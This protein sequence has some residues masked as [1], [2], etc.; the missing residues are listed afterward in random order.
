[1]SKRPKRKK[2]WK[3]DYGKNEVKPSYED[4]YPRARAPVNQVAEAD[5]WK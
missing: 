4:R 1:M 5:R 3:K 2:R